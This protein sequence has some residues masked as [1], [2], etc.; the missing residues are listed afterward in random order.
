MEVVKSVESVSIDGT[1]FARVLEKDS[2]KLEE[3]L[4][5]VKRSLNRDGAIK[6]CSRFNASENKKGQEKVIEEII[7]SP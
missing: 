6:I 5:L 7:D 4:H 1:N 3:R 2:V